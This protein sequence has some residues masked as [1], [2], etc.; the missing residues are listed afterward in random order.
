MSSDTD[1]HPEL[2]VVLRS[3]DGPDVTKACGAGQTVEVSIRDGVVVISVKGGARGQAAPGVAPSAPA[4]QPEPVDELSRLRAQRALAELGYL[5]TRKEAAA[6]TRRSVQTFD[7]YMRPLLRNAGTPARPLY[8]KE[9][10]DRCLQN[11][12]SPGTPTTTSASTPGASSTASGS[13][14][15]GYVTKSRQARANLIRLRRTPSDSTPK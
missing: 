6:Y 12:P 15:R 8:L 2:S 14:T 7:R 13:P 11:L 10:I 9:D 5:L 3:E 4:Q 1:E